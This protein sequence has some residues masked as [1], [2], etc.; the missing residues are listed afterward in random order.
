MK[1]NKTSIF[2]KKKNN[3]NKNIG[4]QTSTFTTMGKR[5]GRLT[6]T[7][8]GGVVAATT[9]LGFKAAEFNKMKAA[10]EHNVYVQAVEK[11]KIPV[12]QTNEWAKIS[13]IY[14]LNPTN[15]VDAAWIRHIEK[16]SKK[17]GISVPN[18]LIT[19]EK[20]QVNKSQIWTLNN[21]LRVEKNSKKRNQ[22]EKIILVLR[23]T[24]KLDSK[25]LNNQISRMRKNRGSLNKIKKLDKNTQ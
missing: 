7:I 25:I 3:S 4:V 13:Q 24:I 15:V 22:I 2:K 14:K 20:N 23:E 18:V 12:R 19:I 1:S 21:N 16:V 11:S 17:T 6:T 9:L 10:K 8:A 5:G